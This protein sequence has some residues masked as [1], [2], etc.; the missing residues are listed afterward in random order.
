[1]RKH[2][3]FPYRRIVLFGSR[4][5]V[6]ALEVR[7]I[8]FFWWSF[9]WLSHSLGL[10]WAINIASVSI[11]NGLIEFRWLCFFLDTNCVKSMLTVIDWTLVIW[12]F[13]TSLWPGV[14]ISL[15]FHRRIFL[16]FLGLV[17]N[18]IVFA[19]RLAGSHG[20]FLIVCLEYHHWVRLHILLIV[21]KHLSHI[22]IVTKGF[23]W[24]LNTNLYFSFYRLRPCPFI[25]QSRVSK[26][27]KLL[28]L[29]LVFLMELDRLALR[30]HGDWVLT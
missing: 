4:G 8:S 13:E 2:L 9:D 6:I 27:S 7:S 10:E 30:W 16:Q 24:A 21:D 26:G 3:V 15:G 23:V 19:F 25:L 18:V 14:E 12:A 1:M 28:L 22:L 5:L 17:N 29:N 11:L 20:N